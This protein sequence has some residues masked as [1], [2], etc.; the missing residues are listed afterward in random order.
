MLAKIKAFPFLEA[1]SVHTVKWQARVI[2]WL[3]IICPSPQLP[4]ALL[5]VFIKKHVY[6]NPADRVLVELELA[7][8]T[9]R[10]AEEG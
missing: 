5:S 9:F 4:R 8:Q 2:Q 6:P 3:L 7:Q 10:L 1:E